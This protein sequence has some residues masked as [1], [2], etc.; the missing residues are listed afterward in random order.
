[1]ADI[2]KHLA[3]ENIAIDTGRL[4]RRARPRVNNEIMVFLNQVMAEDDELTARRARCLLAEKWPTFQ[5]SLPTLK[6]VRKNL[7]WVCTR[8]HYC[9]L[10]WDDVLHDY[11]LK[12]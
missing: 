3:E 6:R 2:R 4:T 10:L 8:P 1:M 11:T 7:G 12:T 5:V 9:Q